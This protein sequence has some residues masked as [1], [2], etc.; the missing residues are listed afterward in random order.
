MIRSKYVWMAGALFLTAACSGGG[1]SGGA[2]TPPLSIAFELSGAN[3]NEGAAPLVVNVVLHTTLGPTTAA[4]TVDVVD[5]GTGT[6]TGGSDYTFAAQTVTFP[7]G[8]VDGAMQAVSFS[9]VNDMS[10]EGAS[11]TAKLTLANASGAPIHG[12]TQFTATIGD[13]HQATVQFSA[14]SSATPNESSAPRT[15]TISLDLPS[16][17]TLATSA[18]VR[19]SDIG[20]GSAVSGVDYAAFAATN[21]TFAPGSADGTTQSITM[22]VIDD[23]NIEA[24]ESVRFGMTALAASTT[25]GSTSTHQLTIMD[26]DATSSSAFAATEGANGTENTLAYDQLIDLG[27]QTVAA[28]SNAGTRVRV[29]N[30]GGAALSLAAPRVTGTDT[31]DFDVE[32]ETAPNPPPAALVP[33]PGPDTLSPLLERAP[34]AGPGLAVALDLAQLEA[35]N[36]LERATLVGFPIPGLDDVALELSQV[37]LPVAPDAV[38]KVDGVARAGGLRAALDDLTLWTGTVRDQ[39]NSHVFLALSS[40]GS[41]GIID[42]G[43]AQDTIVHLVPD[44]SATAPGLPPGCRVVR[45]AEMAALG[46]GQSPD[47]CADS[48]QVPGAGPEMAS[49]ELGAAPATGMLLTANCRLAVETDYQLYQ[50]FGSTNGVT[51][52]VTQ[53]IAAV[54]DRYFHDVQATL[55][56]AYLGVYTNAADPW[57]SQDS[58]GNSS[59]LLDE[60]RAA[61]APNNWPV[62]ANL[63]HFISGASLGGG[64]AYINTLCNAN[65]GFGVSGNISGTIN[66]GSWTGA[67]GSFTWDFVV[68]AHELGHNFGSQHTHSFCPPLDRCSSNCQSTTACTRGT[69]MSYCHVCGGM[70]NIDLEFHPVCSNVMR[71]SVN[72]SC[73]GRSALGGGEYVQYR[74]RFNPLTTTGTKNATL[75]F[76]H[77]ATNVTQPFRVRLQGTAN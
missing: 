42:L 65:Y 15:M 13:I 33:P 27:S 6:A 16:G 51:N 74:V 43:F 25:V 68:V 71:Q 21:V 62:S 38:L 29:A 4:T 36:G 39:P 69:I 64:I 46:F 50:K 28:G 60:F 66:W 75:E 31:N 1:S 10:V 77:D 5:T 59:A 72:A 76:A 45:E 3:V 63:A 48:L 12:T 34:L 9:A 37:P 58:G 30:V 18:T 41:R 53:L 54:S 24:N 26:D 32:L 20:G 55:S 57:T 14:S 7:T 22:Q 67:P 49:L 17:V 8:S 73:I 47:V 19:V 35:L 2:S 23:A 56:I 52:Y 40:T 61:W 44:A 11:E 70:S